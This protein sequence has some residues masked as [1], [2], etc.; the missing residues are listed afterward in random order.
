MSRDGTGA[1]QIVLPCD[2]VLDDIEMVVSPG[3]AT[4]VPVRRTSTDHTQTPP[5]NPASNPH[6][7]A[8]LDSDSSEEEDNDEEE[9]EEE[10][11]EEDKADETRRTAKSPSTADETPDKNLPRLIKMQEIYKAGEPM[12]AF[13]DN[14]QGTTADGKR[15]FSVN[16]IRALK[17]TGEVPRTLNSP[18]FV[19]LLMS[20]VSGYGTQDRKHRRRRNILLCEHSATRFVASVFKKHTGL[21]D[22]N[23]IEARTSQ[24]NVHLNRLNQLNSESVVRDLK[25]CA[26]EDADLIQLLV[27]RGSADID[28]PE[29]NEQLKLYSQFA[30]K[31]GSGNRQFKQ[32]LRE[33]SI[34]TFR[35]ILGTESSRMTVMQTISSWIAYMLE[36]RII[37]RRDF[38]ECLEYIIK[39]QHPGSRAV[40]VLRIP[41]LVCGKTLDARKY[42]EAATFYS[43]LQRNVNQGGYLPFLVSDL[44]QLRSDHW[45]VV[46]RQ[47]Q[48]VP[49]VKKPVD[50][51][52]R[53]VVD[54][55]QEMKADF[56]QWCESD[57]NHPM[58]SYG[59][60]FGVIS[61]LTF[62]MFPDMVKCGI[63][64]V[65]W[66]AIL[67]REMKPSQFELYQALKKNFQR[68]GERVLEE[69]NTTLW[70]IAFEFLGALQAEGVIPFELVMRYVEREIPR[71]CPSPPMVAILEAISSV[72]SVKADEMCAIMNNYGSQFDPEIR[73]VLISFTE[74][75]GVEKTDDTR[76]MEACLSLRELLLRV[77][78]DVPMNDNVVEIIESHE[79]E[80]RAVKKNHPSVFIP[81]CTRT[82]DLCDLSSLQYH[83]LVDWIHKV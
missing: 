82:L 78:T 55:E 39:H 26:L 19:M 71:S 7:R 21:Y 65:T 10:E 9:T 46:Q 23:S 58:Q 41:L 15:I 38:F 12:R 18:G 73:A 76:E 44:L 62:K 81:M 68:H 40:E 6:R 22:A 25:A 29:N 63:D 60:N 75:S 1:T 80:I 69:D 59:V 27:D 43:F 57:G 50:R 14:M 61:G 70:L 67:W 4:S 32:L 16:E 37:T 11:E 35:K 3:T 28:S 77:F 47:E 72:A 33:Q 17:P 52:E 64:F 20:C 83:E 34:A 5:S 51:S 56:N 13:D 42:Y 30:A 74:A 8:T 49:V 24:A 31:M 66:A 79:S 2:R 36:L 48:A 45:T 54:V 53:D